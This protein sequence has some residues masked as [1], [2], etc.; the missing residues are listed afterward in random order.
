MLVMGAL[1][2][3]YDT[4]ALRELARKTR[5]R[6]HIRHLLALAG[7]LVARIGGLVPGA[8]QRRRSALSWPWMQPYRA[9]DRA[10]HDAAL[11][12]RGSLMVRFTEEAITARRVEPRAT[13]GWQP[14]YSAPA[15]LRR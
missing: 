2:A 15:I 13:P 9:V 1:R 10:E 6:W 12:Q 11:R 4:A 3:D 14:H 8:G 7:D 5:D